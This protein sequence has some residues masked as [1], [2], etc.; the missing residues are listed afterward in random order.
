[1]SNDIDIY[2]LTNFNYNN[3]PLYII[4]FSKNM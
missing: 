3:D 2:D 1:M 4:D